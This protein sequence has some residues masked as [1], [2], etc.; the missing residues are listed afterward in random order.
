M[1]DKVRGERSKVKGIR[2][3]I[4]MKKEGSLYSKRPTTS[5]T[6]VSPVAT[7]KYLALLTGIYG[8]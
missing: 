7:F 2:K 8:R 5:R 6:G 1:R 3:E 4:F